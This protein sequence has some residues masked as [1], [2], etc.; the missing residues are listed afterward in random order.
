MYLWRWISRKGSQDSLLVFWSHRCCTPL[1][2]TL[3]SS[4][5]L[6]LDS[7]VLEMIVRPLLG[8]LIECFH[9]CAMM[10]FQTEYER[11]NCY[12][13]S[14]ERYYDSFSY[15][16]YNESLHQQQHAAEK[17]KSLRNEFSTFYVL[18]N[19]LLKEKGICSGGNE[20]MI[21]LRQR[22]I[23]CRQHLKLDQWRL[24][25]LCGTSKCL[26]IVTEVSK[27]VRWR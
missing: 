11:S 15:R 5:I 12:R 21:R 9:I 22:C 1:V 6:S 4:L 26:E 23:K 7:C 8:I 27:K 20:R 24:E 13:I 3:C 18:Q 10:A 19:V 25:D 2:D 17:I 16:S 14:V